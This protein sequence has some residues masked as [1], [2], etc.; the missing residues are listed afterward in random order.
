MGLCAWCA[1][2][3]KCLTL[4][5]QEPQPQQGEESLSGIK[6]NIDLLTYYL[7]QKLITAMKLL[8]TLIIKTVFGYE[9]YSSP[10]PKLPPPHPSFPLN[11]L[12]TRESLKLGLPVCRIP[13]NI[14]LGD[15][16]NFSL[17]NLVL[18]CFFLSWTFSNELKPWN[19]SL[20]RIGLVSLLLL[21]HQNSLPL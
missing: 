3:M 21:T 16:G 10:Q 5:V 4:R 7:N 6:K 17:W 20:I 2:Y 19:K 12:L 1:S 11:P 14:N 13:K 8:R 9:D 15:P 18:L